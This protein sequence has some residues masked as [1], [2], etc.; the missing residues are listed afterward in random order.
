MQRFSFSA[1]LTCF[2]WMESVW[3]PVI[4]HSINRVRM[5]SCLFWMFRWAQPRVLK[6]TKAEAVPPN[7]S[8]DL[9]SFRQ[10]LPFTWV[11]LTAQLTNLCLMGL[12]FVHMTETINIKAQAQVTAPHLLSACTRQGLPCST[13]A[14]SPYEVKCDGAVGGLSAA[15]YS[16]VTFP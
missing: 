16:L 3:E 13:S 14:F 10:T 11:S 8:E 4:E 7:F 15:G 5:A 6:V 9:K 1:S 2:L 12:N